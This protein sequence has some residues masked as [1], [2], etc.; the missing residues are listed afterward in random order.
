MFRENSFQ[1]LLYDI[2]PWSF[3]IIVFAFILWLTLGKPPVPDTDI[4]LWEHTD[5]IVHAIM[6]GTLFFA[7]SFDYYRKHPTLLPKKCSGKMGIFLLITVVIGA[8]IEITQP[9]FDRT[10][11]IYDFLADVA[12]TVIAFIITPPILSFLLI[13]KSGKTA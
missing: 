12:G 7:L 10:A 4:E 6:F 9:Y 8:L 2:W 5:K 11:D 13:R 3:S 1:R